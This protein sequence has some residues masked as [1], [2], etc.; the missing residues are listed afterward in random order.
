M[1][2]PIKLFL[3]TLYE[4]L[5]NT[6]LIQCRPDFDWKLT[7]QMVCQPWYARSYYPETEVMQSTPLLF[8]MPLKACIS[9]PIIHHNTLFLSMLLPCSFTAKF[10]PIKWVDDGGA[11]F[12]QDI[13]QKKLYCRSLVSIHTSIRLVPLYLPADL[14]FFAIW[15]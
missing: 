13:L 2:Q 4:L 1:Y 14:F 5:S 7:V 9:A 15:H 3:H 8:L 10:Q 11:A 6:G 12:G